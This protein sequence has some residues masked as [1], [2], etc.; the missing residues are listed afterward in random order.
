MK[1]AGFHDPCPTS[2]PYIAFL[3]H[4][5]SVPKRRTARRGV[6]QSSYYG[7]HVGSQE[8]PS[9]RR[10]GRGGAATASGVKLTPARDPGGLRFV[11][12]VP[13]ALLATIALTLTSQHLLPIRGHSTP[14]ARVSSPRCLSQNPIPDLVGS[15]GASWHI[16]ILDST[17]SQRERDL[18]CEAKVI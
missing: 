12:Q 5:R 7:R 9:G 14:P 13:A 4:V 17:H 11:P 10:P 8:P 18:V 1:A 3:P 15:R 6:Q 2:D 16:L